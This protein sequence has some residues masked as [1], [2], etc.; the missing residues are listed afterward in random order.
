MSLKPEYGIRPCEF[1]GSRFVGS[2]KKIRSI[3]LAVKVSKSWLAFTGLLLLLLGSVIILNGNLI[4]AQ[5][6]YHIF[7]GP[8]RVPWDSAVDTCH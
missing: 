4:S 3:V 8:G 5:V 6:I 1:S 2:N 7:G